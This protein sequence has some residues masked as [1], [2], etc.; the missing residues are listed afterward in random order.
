MG[1]GEDHGGEG[2]TRKRDGGGV[3]ARG[4]WGGEG[5]MGGMV[6]SSPASESCNR[7]EV[8]SLG[9]PLSSEPF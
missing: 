7:R 2:V 6:I 1:E 8:M 4:T 5:G 9:A 3:W